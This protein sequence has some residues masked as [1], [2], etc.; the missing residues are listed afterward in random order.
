MSLKRNRYEELQRI[1]AQLENKE[2][3]RFATLRDRVIEVVNSLLQKHRVPTRSMIE[4][5][6]Q[7]T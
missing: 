3:Q 1:V 6:I 7:V 2:L 5:L 4:N